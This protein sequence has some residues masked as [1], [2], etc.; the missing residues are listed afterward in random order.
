MKSFIQFCESYKPK[1]KKML[2]KANSSEHHW[3]QT[4]DNRERMMQE[5]PHVD[6]YVSSTVSS[7]NVL[8]VLDFH[9]EWVNLGLI[10]AKDWNINLCQSPN[11]YR[12]D[13]FPNDFK[14]NVI[15]PAYEKHI[16]WLE[17]QDSLKRATNG[18]K[19]VVNLMNSQD[20]THHWDKFV[21]EIADL[22]RVREEDFWA[23][24]PEFNS[25]K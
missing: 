20:A 11:W 24:F 10:K 23:T 1:F 9:R 3:Q 19:S 17:P 6:F 18:F 14:K 2:N 7:M 13:I 25:L 15:Q 4:V 22:D 5:V 16:A 12:P 21:F 8:H